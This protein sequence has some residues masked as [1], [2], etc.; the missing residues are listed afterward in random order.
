MERTRCYAPWRRRRAT[1]GLGILG[2]K[3][4][5]ATIAMKPQPDPSTRKCWR[6]SSSASRTTMRRTVS[7]F[8]GS[9]HAATATALDLELTEGSVIADS[10]GETPCVF[11]A[12]L[13]RAE[14][15]IADRVM[16]LLGG[17]RRGRAWVVSGKG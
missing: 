16:R 10:V 5:D 9:G 4:D 8:C 6:D 1:M 12:G 15:V 3:T 14:R 17:A 11:L 13:H 7:A 2:G